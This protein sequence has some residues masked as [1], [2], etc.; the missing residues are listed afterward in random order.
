MA[1]SV[2][3]CHH[4][5]A[6]DFTGKQKAHWAGVR[7]IW[8]QLPAR[9]LAS[10]VPLPQI[11]S[12]RRM[13]E[14][15]PSILITVNSYMI[16]RSSW[17]L[18][19]NGSL[20]LIPQNCPSSPDESETSLHPPPRNPHPSQGDHECPIPGNCPTSVAA[21]LPPRSRETKRLTI[22]RL[23]LCVAKMRAKGHQKLSIFLM[24]AS[25]CVKKRR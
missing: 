15:S 19:V 24:V 16:L 14:M 10:F 3:F 7:K 21:E 11:W 23:I 2:V 4:G 9:L 25:P 8:I 22:G 18:S 12:T 13:K 6:T 5:E 1:P 20:N 17:L